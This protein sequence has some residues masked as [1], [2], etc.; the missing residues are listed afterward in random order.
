MANYR[1]KELEIGV[2]PMDRQHRD[3][4]ERIDALGSGWPNRPSNFTNRSG[5]N[6]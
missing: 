2:S 5:E 4:F 6:P 1:T 3:R